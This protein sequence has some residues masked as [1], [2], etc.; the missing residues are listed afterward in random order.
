MK[1]IV[2]LSLLLCCMVC[3]VQTFAKSDEP[4]DQIVAVVNDDV[5]TTSELKVALTSTKMQIAQ[6]HVPEPSDAILKK[7][8]LE[9]LV[10]KKLQLQIAKTGSIQVTDSDVD[11]A[12]EHIAQQNNVP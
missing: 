5:I 12:V 4:L 2:S 11:K 7:Q 3:A 10:N 8:V 1:K 9:Q 6:E